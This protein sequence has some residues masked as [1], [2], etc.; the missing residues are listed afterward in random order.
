MKTDLRM[1][2]KLAELAKR[3]ILVPRTENNPYL[4]L[5]YRGSGGLVSEK[6][7][8]KIYTSDSVTCTDNVIL[9]DMLEDRLKPPSNKICI[10]IDDAGWGF[11]LCGVMCGI[12][13]G[14]KVVTCMTDV[15]FFQ[16]PLFQSK[17]YLHEYALVG[18]DTMQREF[19]T[20]PQTHRVEICTRYVNNGLRDL[21][22]QK[23]Y[24]VRTVEIKGLLQEELESR[25][26][27]YVRETVGNDLAYDPKEVPKRELGKLFWSVVKWGRKNAPHLLKTGWKSLNEIK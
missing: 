2:R 7:N 5:S 26:R 14:S 21:L 24:E 22:R 23:G 15:R 20:D 13:D 4:K 12:T 1:E 19:K 17:K 27:S 8:I 18:F 11:A 25:F 16:S 6:W 3:G 9:Q 10:Q